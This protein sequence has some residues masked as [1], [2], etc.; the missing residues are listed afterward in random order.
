MEGNVLKSFKL[1]LVARTI[2]LD[3]IA[4]WAISII[5]KITAKIKRRSNTPYI[6]VYF[7]A[8]SNSKYYIYAAKPS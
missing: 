2:G 6:G 1:I 4:Y 5:L 3:I 7:M 8:I